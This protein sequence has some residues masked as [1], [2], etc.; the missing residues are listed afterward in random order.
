MEENKQD[1]NVESV[2]VTNNTPKKKFTIMVC[3]DGPHV[4]T[5]FG[6]VC[7]ELVMRW[8]ETGKYKIV[9]MAMN[10]RGEFHPLRQYSQ[11]LIIEPLPFIEQDAYGLQRFPELL[12]KY[13]PDIVFALNDL[14]V[15]T[16]DE[17]T[18]NMDHWMYKA[19]KSYKPYLPFVVYFPVDGHPW[20]QKWVA[21]TSY[22]DYAVT[23]TDYGKKIL[24]RTPGINKDK[25]RTIYHGHSSDKFFPISEREKLEQRKRMGFDED[26]FVIGMVA[27]NQ[28]RKHIPGLMEAFKMFSD[29]YVVCAD[30]NRYRSI[31]VS[32]E[33]EYCGSENFVPGREGIEKAKLYL[34]M[35][36]IDMRGYKIPRM[37]RVFK[38]TNAVMPVNHDVASGVPI[39]ELN[40]IYNCLNVLV[41]PAISGGYELAPAE[42]MAAGTPIVVTRST[43]MVE[44]AD[45][46]KGWIV[47]PSC[48]TTIADANEAFKSYIDADRLVDTLFEIYENKEEAQRRAEKA[49]EFARERT[50]ARSAAEF[51]ELFTNILSERQSLDLYLDPTKQNM[52]FANETNNFGNSL[53]FVPVLNE[54]AKINKEV[55]FVY[56]TNKRCSV[57]LNKL[58]PSIKIIDISK[59]W[60]DRE[61]LSRINYQ[62]H[63][64]AEIQRKTEAQLK[65]VVSPADMPS[66]IESFARA[67]GVYDKLDFKQLPEFYSITDRER[68][69]AIET[70]DSVVPDDKLKVC[71]VVETSNP[72][73]GVPLD[74][75]SQ[76]FTFLKKMKEVAIIA[77]GAPEILANLDADVKI[78]DAPIRNILACVGHC[79]VVVTATEEYAHL[80]NV[81]DAQ[82]VIIQ[83]P[84]PLNHITK[85][86]KA[87][88]A[89]GNNLTQYVSLAEKYP[90]MPCF[91]ET[92]EPCSVT[93]S[94]YSHCMM[95]MTGGTIFSKLLLIK[96]RWVKEQA[97]KKAQNQDQKN[98][99]KTE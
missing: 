54:I 99:E 76:L 67:L 64:I 35:N 68:N 93:G 49:L 43:S 51:D 8:L 80:A 71:V 9:C 20:D 96:S 85:H 4:T 28:P 22:M 39:D 63:G 16:G 48:V 60:L 72:N 32:P 13:D 3:T 31:D 98:S 10:D 26:S 30:C 65:G 53:S 91:K 25:V 75:W 36:S 61:G 45:N 66:Q 15:L 89:N 17:R 1:F 11:D 41:N 56:A 69:F 27:R 62:I 14:W 37:Q 5:G 19:I 29:G 82:F 95:S 34:H 40:R 73:T 18:T 78:S 21:A 42:A 44:L 2:E 90:C 86:A 59:M 46:E 74:T 55:N 23:F 97:A 50:W 58:D 38:V 7:N 92:L 88:D 70:I 87:R 77:I 12:R 94:P 52:V 33:C 84:K 6:R 81:F 83:G 24:N 57:L 47:N 79:N